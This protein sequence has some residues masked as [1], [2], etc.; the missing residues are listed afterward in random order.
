MI[1][2]FLGPYAPK[3]GVGLVYK[4]E[5]DVLRDERLLDQST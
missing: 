1:E 4:P 5:H 3:E 2:G